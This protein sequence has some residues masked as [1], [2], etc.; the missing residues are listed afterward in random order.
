[1]LNFSTQSLCVSCAQPSGK[2]VAMLPRFSTARSLTTP[3]VYSFM[4]YATSFAQFIYSIFRSIFC[5]IT[6]VFVGVFHTIHR[7]YNKV[8]QRKE[9]DLLVKG[10][11]ERK[12]K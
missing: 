5:S 12:V 8:L 1:M 6:S 4:T 7:T 9:K 11:D 3:G 10:G 2:T